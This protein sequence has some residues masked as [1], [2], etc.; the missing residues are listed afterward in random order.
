MKITHNNFND[1]FKKKQ[2]KQ[3]NMCTSGPVFNCRMQNLVASLKQMYAYQWNIEIS[4]HSPFLLL[5]CLYQARKMSYHVLVCPTHI[6]LCF[7]F[8]CLR[9]VYLM[10]PV[11]LDCPKVRHSLTF[12][13]GYIF[14]SFYDF[15]VGLSNF[16]DRVVF[17]L[18]FFSFYLQSNDLLF[19]PR[20]FTSNMAATTI[21]QCTKSE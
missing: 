14:I 12:I 11:S 19:S 7:C 4:K 1:L 6:V 17:F 13:Y 16:S 18:F 20:M 8:V 2:K 21:V 15:S 10:L 9:L 5:K 3:D